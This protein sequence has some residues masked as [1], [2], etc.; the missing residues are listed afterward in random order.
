MTEHNEGHGPS[1]AGPPGGLVEVLTRWEKSGG[2]WEVL[3]SSVGWV[4][5]GLL[6]CEGAE[7]MGRVRGARTSVLH[8]YLGGRTSSAQSPRGSTRDVSSPA[9]QIHSR[10]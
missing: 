9:R 6:T 4:E 2:R 7:P 5:I 3:T 10:T 8:D 1:E